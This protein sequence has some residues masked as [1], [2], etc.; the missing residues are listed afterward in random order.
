[1]QEN[2]QPHSQS[3][4]QEQRT[5]PYVPF[6]T[7]LTAVEILQQGLPRKL[8]RAQLRSMSGTAQ[9][10]SIRAFRFLGL[11]DAQDYV[12]PTMR[13]FVE[14]RDSRK[15]IMREILEHAY[16]DIVQLGRDHGSVQELRDAIGR[17]NVQGATARKAIAFFLKS[18]EFAGLELSPVW[19]NATRGGAANGRA[20]SKGRSTQRTPKPQIDDHDRK[21]RGGT[22][23]PGTMHTVKLTGGGIVQLSVVADWVTA[24]RQDREWLTRLVDTFNSY[25]M[26]P[27]SSDDTHRRVR[28][29][30][31]GPPPGEEVDPDD[32][33]FD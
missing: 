8:D 32:L 15:Q 12:Q 25:G 28:A 22:P 19:A 11:I 10:E 31:N 14:E 6:K 7:F 33:P 16:P 27:E 13:R 9:N 20:R 17:Y 2:A 18:A 29:A 24:T 1:M 30:V 3:Q 4:Q 21:P 26:E 5:A 23:M